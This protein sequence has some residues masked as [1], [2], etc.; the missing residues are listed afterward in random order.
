MLCGGAQVMDVKSDSLQV[1]LAADSLIH[2]V[3]PFDVAGC[4][5]HA[6]LLYQ[7]LHACK[8]QAALRNVLRIIP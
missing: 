5:A 6:A 2:P 8:T 4:P 3:N 7:C 1:G